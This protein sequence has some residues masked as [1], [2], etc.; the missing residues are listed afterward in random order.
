MN[1]NTREPRNA[2]LAA[3]HGRTLARSPEHPPP[4]LKAKAIRIA[5]KPPNN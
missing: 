1:A 2:V 3:H 4:E 5:R